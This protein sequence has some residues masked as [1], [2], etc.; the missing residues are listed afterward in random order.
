MAPEVY[1]DQSDDAQVD[2]DLPFTPGTARSALSRK[3]FRSVWLGT[4]SSNVGTWM[5]NLALGVLAYDLTHSAS[6]V[7]LIGFAQLGPLFALS[8]LGGALADVVD[9]KRLLVICQVEQL[10]FSLVLAWTAAQHH[11]S[12]LLIFL[13]VLAI[14]IGNAVNAPAFTAVLPLLV[15]KEDLPGAVSLQSV[16]MNLSR[17]IGPAIAGVLLPVVHPSGIF[18]INAVTYLFAVYVIVRVA[19]PSV[20]APAHDS[21][22]QRLLGGFAVARRDPLVRYCLVTV[23]TISFFCLPFV[24][25]MP[26][27]A[28]R[29]LH[30][31]PSGSIYGWLYAIFGLGAALG[32]VSVG[33]VFVTLPRRNLIR[34]GL[35]AFTVFLALF[36]LVGNIFW[37][38][39]TAFLLG[40]AYFVTITS[41]STTLQAHIPNEVRGRVMA[42]WIMGFGGTVPLG[43]LV[44]GSVA[45]A[46]SVRTVVLAGAAV[47]ALVTLMAWLTTATENTDLRT[48]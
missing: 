15:P 11:P 29:D 43:L 36:G 17:V 40:Y 48:I 4:T 7:A 47:A 14:G 3:V 46:T 9:R 10:L 35:G 42:L 6:Y 21:I 33:S 18:V 27:I 24:G 16:Q 32:A 25:L 1:V 19:I 31:A 39:P 44:A 37:A 12:T 20:K 38:F 22:A 30:I 2:G 13:C 41:L 45:S 26:V 34:G 28:A 5:Q 23:A 8:I